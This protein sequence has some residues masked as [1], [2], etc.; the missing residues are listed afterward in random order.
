MALGGGKFCNQSLAGGV[1]DGGRGVM[2]D[3]GWGWIPPFHTSH[4]EWTFLT[5]KEIPQKVAEPEP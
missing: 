3:A 2:S 4:D 5:A 1:S